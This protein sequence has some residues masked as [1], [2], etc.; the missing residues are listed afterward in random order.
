MDRG[1]AGRCEAQRKTIKRE[2][3]KDLSRGGPGITA[4]VAA[5]TMAAA[6]VLQ[7]QDMMGCLAQ[8]GGLRQGAVR[9]RNLAPKAC[10]AKPQ[11]QKNKQEDRRKR[12]HHQLVGKDRI[13]A[14]AAA[15]RQHEEQC[16]ACSQG[17]GQAIGTGC[18]APSARAS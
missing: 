13:K 8:S 3:M 11:S 10:H 6:Q 17:Q 14:A 9:R 15:G 12:T 7:R 4:V 2:V 16:Q 18:P 5:F 1:Q